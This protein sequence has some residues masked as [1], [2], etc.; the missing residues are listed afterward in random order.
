MK[1]IILVAMLLSLTGCG[2]VNRILG[3]GFGYTT[4]CVEETHVM[5]VQFPSGAAVLVDQTGKPV[6]CK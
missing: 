4:I 1:K 5:Y 2:Y 3:Y 6:P